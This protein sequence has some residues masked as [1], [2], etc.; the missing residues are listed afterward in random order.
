MFS[1]FKIIHFSQSLRNF[2]VYKA[3]SLGLLSDSLESLKHFF[4]DSAENRGSC[5]SITWNWEEHGSDGFAW[6]EGFATS[7]QQCATM[8]I[9]QFPHQQL[10]GVS[11]VEEYRVCSS[12]VDWHT[13]I[14]TH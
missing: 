6:V 5:L 1:T 9:S 8:A 14:D 13:L 12:S 2:R 7:I 11:C 3:L 4:C 10:W